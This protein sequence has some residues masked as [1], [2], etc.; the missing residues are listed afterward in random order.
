MP[1]LRIIF[2]LFSFQGINI[3][4]ENIR[5]K[6][7][8]TY[9]FKPLEE[10]D[11][12]LLFNWQQNPHVA[13]WWQPACEWPYFVKKYRQHIAADYIFPFIMQVNGTSIGYIQYYH[14]NMVD[15]EWFDKAFGDDK[16]SVVGIDIFIGNPDYFAKGY[17][18]LFMKL[19]I[20]KLWGNGNIKKIIVDPQPENIQA[21]HCFK[22]I[23]FS[24]V[25]KDDLFYMEI[26]R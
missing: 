16:D 7:A 13:W 10:Q 14:V 15:L 1:N 3:N 18:S 22:K 26:N 9:T 8:L 11:F 6:P 17:G 23:G 24:E 2:C 4:T 21:V 19:F 20:E 5:I 12:K 25:Q